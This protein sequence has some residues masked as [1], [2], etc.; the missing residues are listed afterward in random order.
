MADAQSALGQRSTDPAASIIEDWA[1]NYVPG[2][3]PH[4]S[5]YPGAVPYLAL[6]SR[7]RP[8]T[9]LANPCYGNPLPS[10]NGL[11]VHCTA[12]FPTNDPYGV[13]NNICIAGWNVRVASAHFAISGNGTVIQ[14]IPVSYSAFAQGR[15]DASWLSV[16]IDNPGLAPTAAVP[17]TDAQI[18]S[19]QKLFAW[20]CKT[21]TIRPEVA[22]GHLCGDSAYDNITRTVCSAGVLNPGPST[23][24]MDAMTSRGLSCHRWLAPGVKPCPGAGVLSQMLDIASGAA[25][26]VGR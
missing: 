26:L 23:V 19:A 17:A 3:P 13:A 7:S 5:L 24:A 14:F 1:D 8:I 15:G 10:I 6:G 4:N 18:K 16:E 20:V 9:R 12:A 25:T 2:A 21:F 22:V 11:A